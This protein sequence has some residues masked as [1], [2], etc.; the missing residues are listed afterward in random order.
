[1]NPTTMNETNQSFTIEPGAI[2]WAFRIDLAHPEIAITKYVIESGPGPMWRVT[3]GGVRS[4]IFEGE[5]HPTREAA[6]LALW[7]LL[8]AHAQKLN[9][10]AIELVANEHPELTNPLAGSP[11][12]SGIE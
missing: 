4:Y 8:R 1:M 10:L 12:R 7:H 3:N 6:V 11:N 9:N 2:V 5:M